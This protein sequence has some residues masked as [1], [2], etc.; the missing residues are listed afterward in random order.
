MRAMVCLSLVIEQRQFEILRGVRFGQAA[1]GGGRV[2]LALVFVVDHQIVE[3]HQF[4][5]ADSFVRAIKKMLDS[6]GDLLGKHLLDPFPF[7]GRG[8]A[9]QCELPVRPE[10]SRMLAATNNG[11]FCT[12]LSRTNV[13]ERP[14]TTSQSSVPWSR[15]RQ[16]WSMNPAVM[17]RGSASSAA[18]A[19]A[20]FS[21]PAG[22][23][24][25]LECLLYLTGDLGVD[26]VTAA[27]VRR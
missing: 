2:H 3:P 5:G 15:R 13:P 14:P 20:A 25:L 16:S 18:A 8:Q 4:D 27:L 17:Q 26:A 12:T 1:P 24:D 10:T 9:Q 19:A 11:E 22:L 7:H 21:P 23:R 6:H